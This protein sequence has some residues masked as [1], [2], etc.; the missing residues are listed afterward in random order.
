MCACEC[1]CFPVVT[2]GS[3][4]L[5]CFCCAA[6]R[7][8]IFWYVL[9]QDTLAIVNVI[10]VSSRGRFQVL[11][12]EVNKTTVVLSVLF[13]AVVGGRHVHFHKRVQKVVAILRNQIMLCRGPREFQG[14]DKCC[15]LVVDTFVRS[16]Y[17]AH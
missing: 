9:R 2:S 4:P 5:A 10:E 15:V 11:S 16:E 12:F 1:V 13:D 14:S 7:K 3:H 8:A 17:A 6:C